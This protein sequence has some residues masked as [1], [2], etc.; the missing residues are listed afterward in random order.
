LI[1]L[2]YSCISSSHFYCSC[3]AEWLTWIHYHFLLQLNFSQICCFRFPSISDV[4]C[5]KSE[6]LFRRITRGDLLKAYTMTLMAA[7][8]CH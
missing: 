4:D 8:K 6:F 7:A 1:D 5:L 2:T 3:R